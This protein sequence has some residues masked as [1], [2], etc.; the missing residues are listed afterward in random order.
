MERQCIYKDRKGQLSNENLPPDAEV[1][2]ALAYTL[3]QDHCH[4]HLW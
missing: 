3:S 1:H 2:Q 4:H